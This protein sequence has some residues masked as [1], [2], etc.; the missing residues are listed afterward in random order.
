MSIHGERRTPIE[1]KPDPDD[2][3]RTQT[4]LAIWQSAKPAQGTPVEAYLASRGIDLSVPDALRF[5]AGL[6]HPSGS[7]WPA[8]VALVT[9]G[10]TGTAVAVHRTFIVRNGKSK[11]PVN[12]QKMMLGPVRGAAVRLGTPQAD[13]PLAVSEGLETGLSVMVACGIPVWAALSANGIRALVLP[14]VAREVIIIADHDAN[15]IGESAARDAGLRWRKEGREVRI[16]MPP[17]RGTDF[18]DVLLATE[19][20]E[21]CDVR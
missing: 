9:N 18:A 10:A 4:A 2:A 17:E 11:A 7:V 5:H 21:V 16:A 15:G 6:K 8:M 19:S 20:A 13:R 14:P 3:K 12:P 1:R